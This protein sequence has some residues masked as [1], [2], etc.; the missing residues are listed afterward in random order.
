MAEHPPAAEAGKKSGW[1]KAIAGTLV[2]L[3]SG[4]VVTYVT[5]LVDHLVKPGKPLANF[6]KDQ[7]GLTVTFH[8]RS[9][10]GSEGWWDFGDGS[11]LE[12]VSPSENA[13]THTYAKPGIYT[14]KL[15]LRNFIG[16]ESDRTVSI[17]LDAPRPDEPGIAALDVVPVSP[18]VYAPAT[19][20]ISSKVQN[21]DLCIYEFGEGY[22]LKVVN[23]P[24]NEPEQMITF[25]RPGNHT[26]RLVAV[27][28][29]KTVE[30]N[31]VV[32]VNPP[33]AGMVS[34]KLIAAA[35]ATRVEKSPR[36]EIVTVSIPPDFRD[37]VYSFDRI[38][39]PQQ[40]CI[41]ASAKLERIKD[42]GAGNLGL[43]ITAN[44]GEVHLTGALKKPSGWGFKKGQAP[45]LVVRVAMVQERRTPVTGP[46]EDLSVPL[47]V[48]GV[49]DIPLPPLHAEWANAQWSLQL[50]LTQDDRVIREQSPL[51]RGEA[52]LIQNRPCKLTA[53]VVGDRVRIELAEVKP[54]PGSAVIGA[55]PAGSPVVLGVGPTAP[56]ASPPG[57]V[58]PA[59]T[60][61]GPQHP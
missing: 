49:A 42:P 1:F 27:N 14:A 46:S 61:P 13:V 56:S 38:I 58:I 37:T 3:L 60:G 48:P 6:N 12:P 22:P 39:R 10:G 47:Q 43:A 29:K 2:G 33:P 40:G 44:G 17:N 15:S 57:G 34:V 36:P 26:V 54:N 11:P 41:I 9:T 20:R 59:P 50:A 24:A 8:N 55:P 52:V 7:Q 21:A 45:E 31:Q 28:G 16:E 18:G 23:E 30:R 5:P 19:F 32:R 51:P 53:T 35:Q 25:R 4:A